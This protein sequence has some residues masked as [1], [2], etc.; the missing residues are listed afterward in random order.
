LIGFHADRYRF[1][2]IILALLEGAARMTA[3]TLTSGA[4][5]S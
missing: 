2:P 4:A 1:R 5:V 3:Q